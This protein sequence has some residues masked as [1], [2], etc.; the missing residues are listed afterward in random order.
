ML[1]SANHQLTVLGTVEA[2]AGRIVLKQTELVGNEHTEIANFDPGRSIFLGSN[3]QLLATGY[4]R[5]EPN[6]Q[7]LRKGEVLDGGN[8]NITAAKG[9]LIAQ[10]GSLIN[11]SGTETTL[12]LVG[13]SG[14]ATLYEIWCWTFWLLNNPDEIVVADT[15]S[16]DD[17][18]SVARG[19]GA[20]V[21]SIEWNHDF[22]EA[23]NCSLA[24]ATGDIL[25]QDDASV[26]LRDESGKLLQ[27]VDV[28][29]LGSRGAVVSP[30]G[31]LI[32][33]EIERRL[34]TLRGVTHVFSI[35]GDTTGANSGTN[36][37][38]YFST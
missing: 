37:G 14:L 22:A 25:I 24:A 3:S 10:Q 15:G 8:V 16:M 17:T 9:Y 29:S 6:A 33:A 30:S 7:N 31:K 21:F 13:A 12:D 1:L 18:V 32:L 5:A 20:H 26:V 11:V 38:W 28:E 19:F 35:I 34:K 36:S 27:R 23:R 4:Y 2:A